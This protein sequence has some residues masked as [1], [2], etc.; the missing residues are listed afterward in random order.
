MSI[1]SCQYKDFQIDI[2]HDEDPINPREF[3]NLSKMIFFHKKYN[4][5]DKHNYISNNYNS[6]E[7]LK[8]DI[9]DVAIIKPVYMYDHS[10]ITIS[11]NKFSCPFDSGQIGYVVVKKEDIYKFFDIKRISKELL[12]K[13][14]EMIEEEIKLY[15]FYLRGMVYRY[16]IKKDSF[17]KGEEEIESCYGF[18]GFEGGEESYVVKTA[19]EVIDL[20]SKKVVYK[21]G[22]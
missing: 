12:K 2:Y 4:L 19:K 1:Y 18:Y 11:L 10:G 17:A 3:E 22:V 13:V 9:K 5:G 20:I 6:W 15:D 8:N 21:N 16:S 14:E 7:E